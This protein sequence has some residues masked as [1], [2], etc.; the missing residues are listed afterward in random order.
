MRKPDKQK[1]P[2]PDGMRERVLQSAAQE[3]GEP[4]TA[5]Y[6]GR[7]SDLTARFKAG[8]LRRDGSP[9]GRPVR[10]FFGTL[11]RR[12]ARGVRYLLMGVF[13]LFCL[14]LSLADGGMGSNDLDLPGR[15]RK[16]IVTGASPAAA[17]VSAG[18]AL[19]TG[20]GH[21]WLVMSCS[22]AGILDADGGKAEFCW[23]NTPGGRPQHAGSGTRWVWPDGSTLALRLP[24]GEPPVP[25]RS[26]EQ[27]RPR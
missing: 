8:G 10:H 11:P 22:R 26:R 7:A 23:Q 12:L 17:A 9:S 3:W 14:A 13:L 19:R 25:Q 2:A 15:R 24:A 4:V 5:L 1:D 20:C 27:P 16:M 21:L 18:R 6:L